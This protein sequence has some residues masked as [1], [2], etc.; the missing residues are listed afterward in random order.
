MLTDLHQN[1]AAVR[2]FVVHLSA[3]VELVSAVP[4]I[5]RVRNSSEREMFVEAQ[6]IL[7]EH[8]IIVGARDVYRSMRYLLEHPIHR[9]MKYL[10]E[11]EIFYRSMKYLSKLDIFSGV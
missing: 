10:F 3:F 7:S 6:D 9:S 8:E 5:S 4:P 2:V 1:C 11:H